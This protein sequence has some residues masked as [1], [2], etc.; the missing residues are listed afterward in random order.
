MIEDPTARFFKKTAPSVKIQGPATP[1]KIKVMEVGKVDKAVAPKKLA[2]DAIGGLT[3]K[4]L[5]RDGVEQR[6]FLKKMNTPPPV[7]HVPTAGVRLAKLGGAVPPAVTAPGAP[8]V[9]SEEI[10]GNRV[11]QFVKKLDE[12]EDEVN[13]AINAENAALLAASKK[14]DAL[15]YGNAL[16]ERAATEARDKKQALD[17][18]RSNQATKLKEAEA[19]AEAAIKR[20]ARATALLTATAPAARTPGM[21]DAVNYTRTELTAAVA[22]VNA[23][24]AAAKDLRQASLKYALLAAAHPAVMEARAAAARGR[25]G[26]SGGAGADAGAGAGAGAD[27][28]FARRLEDNW[29]GGAAPSLRD[30]M[31]YAHERGVPAGTEALAMQVIRRWK[32]TQVPPTAGELNT[33]LRVRAGAGAGGGGGAGGAGGPP[34]PP[35]QG[36]GAGA[37]D[38]A[39][40][41]RMK[42]KY[43]SVDPVWLIQGMQDGFKLNAANNLMHQNRSGGIHPPAAWNVPP[44]AHAA[45]H[46]GTRGGVQ[47]QLVGARFDGPPPPLPR[48]LRE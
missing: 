45:S 4:A 20:Q 14:A 41:A 36:G 16:A 25:A 9:T 30:F 35:A 17:A 34:P 15:E 42:A 40:F 1:G 44:S 29:R 21:H 38:A 28:L 22:K 19:E 27:A 32:N 12:N 8:T 13:G 5:E 11:A 39:M 2:Q 31:I 47:E 33:L 46:P 10:V 24:K 26:T 6:A 23:A 3:N 48:E 43:P 37:L 18:A 7:W